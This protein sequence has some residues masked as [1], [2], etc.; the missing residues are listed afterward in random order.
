MA[1]FGLFGSSF[2]RRGLVIRPGIRRLVLVLFFMAGAFCP[3]PGN[4]TAQ[5]PEA[6]QVQVKAIWLYRFILGTDWPEEV[7][8][9]PAAP[10]VLGVLGID[11][12]GPFLEGMTKKVVRNRPIVVKHYARAE[13]ARDCHLLFISASEESNLETIAEY[14]RDAKILTVGESDRWT[15]VGGVVSFALGTKDTFRVSKK[16][17]KNLENLG[18][19]TS[20]DLMGMGKRIP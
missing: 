14:L 19:K 18:V 8:P 20:S 1:L 5:Q 2:R 17:L 11:P 12:F 16:A 10:Y 6:S 3:S 15:K 13:E 9:N 4:F 7:F